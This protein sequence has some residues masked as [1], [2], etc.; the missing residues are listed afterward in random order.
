MLTDDSEN[1]KSPK[2]YY[3]QKTQKRKIKGEGTR[4]VSTRNIAI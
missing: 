2:E 4:K 1:S 3:S